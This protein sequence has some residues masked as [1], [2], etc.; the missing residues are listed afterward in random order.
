MVLSLIL[1]MFCLLL[2]A[3]SF[4]AG[5]LFG[6]LKSNKNFTININMLDLEEDQGI[7]PDPE[8]MPK[9]VTQITKSKEATT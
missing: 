3:I 1:T 7:D 4:G 5:L 6:H 2:C 8:R 9:N